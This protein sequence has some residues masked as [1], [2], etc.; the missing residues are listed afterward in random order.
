MQIKVIATTN[1][2]NNTGF[3]QLI[4]SMQHFGINYEIIN[5]NDS[6]HG[7]WARNYEALYEWCKTQDPNQEFLYTDGFDTFFVAG[8]DELEPKLRK[9]N[10][11]MLVSGE[12][13]A[14]PSPHLGDGYDDC[15]S[16]WKYVNAG[17]FFTT[18]GY[19]THLIESSS[20]M[21]M[22]GVYS[23]GKLQKINQQD[24]ISMMHLL[25][26][27]D[28]QVDTNCEIFQPLCRIFFGAESTD[29]NP[30]FTMDYE[31]NRLMNNHTKSQP[32]ILHGNGGAVQFMKNIYEMI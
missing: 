5:L 3:R 14:F 26:R 4:R 29:D 11:K 15:D 6:G 22:D 13:V 19:F 9:F 2:V 20:F 8:M 7:A 27:K 18:C 32:V 24:W 10:C 1:D 17:G 23:F 12:G 28:I 31:K 25:F 30:D 21:T 16:P